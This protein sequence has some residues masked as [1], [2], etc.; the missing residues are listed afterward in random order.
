[1][2][3]RTVQGGGLSSPVV[4]QIPGLTLDHADI[5]GPIPNGQ[6]DG[7]L[8]LLDQLHHLG[9]L[10]GCDTAADNGL[11]GTRCLQE[12]HLHV[13]LQ[14]MGLQGEQGTAGITVH[15]QA[16]SCLALPGPYQA[17]PVDDQGVFARNGFQH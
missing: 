4:P 3:P 14:C 17:V 5:V 1:M 15:S 16:L 10:Q 2:G 13:C 12:F 11:A 8:V 6:S 9:F 7:F